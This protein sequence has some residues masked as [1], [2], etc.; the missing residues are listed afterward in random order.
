MHGFGGRLFVLV[1]CVYACYLSHLFRAFS[2]QDDRHKSKES[3]SM[4]PSSSV[5][6]SS[7]VSRLWLLSLSQR[8]PYD[9]GPTSLPRRRAAVPHGC[10]DVAAGLLRSHDG[11][12]SE[13]EEGVV[14]KGLG[15]GLR[16]R[17]ILRLR[18]EGGLR[19][20][21]AAG[22]G[23]SARGGLGK[24]RSVLLR[25]LRQWGV[26]VSAVERGS[27]FEGVGGG[28]GGAATKRD[29]AVS[30]TDSRVGA[31]SSRDANSLE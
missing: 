29:V 13:E 1:Y 27:C 31:S 11:R 14:E 8:H 30:K 25:G 28:E 2:L 18:L 26:C 5:P 4:R 6:S 24:G 23:G 9:P 7:L 19:Y 22:R 3:R 15:S 10:L 12:L 20:G 16:W 17:R 21:R